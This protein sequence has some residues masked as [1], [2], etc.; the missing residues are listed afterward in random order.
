[1]L[2]FQKSTLWWKWRLVSESIC[3][4]C[5]IGKRL[6]YIDIFVFGAI[7][8]ECFHSWACFTE[9]YTEKEKKCFTKY[10]S[11]VV[12]NYMWEHKLWKKRSTSQSYIF[13]P[14]WLMSFNLARTGGCRWQ[15]VW[16]NRWRKWLVFSSTSSTLLFLCLLGGEI[17][18]FL[19]A[20][21]Q[22]LAIKSKTWVIIKSVSI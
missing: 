9:W 13:C 6:Y 5:S 18:L 1:M 2:L 4:L 3:A 16:I 14:L 7:V 22:L 10:F 8:P 12:S 17:F 11:V 15:L 20:L 21:C 19:Q